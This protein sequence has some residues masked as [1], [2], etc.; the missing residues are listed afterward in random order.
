M[1]AGQGSPGSTTSR[2]IARRHTLENVHVANLVSREFPLT[3][4]LHLASSGS[5][6]C[7]VACAPTALKMTVGD[8]VFYFSF[9]RDEKAVVFP[10]AISSARLT[11]PHSLKTHGLRSRQLRFLYLQP[12]AISGRIGREGGS[13]PQ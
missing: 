9:L 8:G 1:A 13:P 3:A 5:F 4:C 7:V 2:V 12:G 11:L 10:I 6:G